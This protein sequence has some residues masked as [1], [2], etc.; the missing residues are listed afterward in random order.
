MYKSYNECDMQT[1]HFKTNAKSSGC[2]YKIDKILK[3]NPSS[4]S[5]NF[6]LV[7][8]HKILSISTD[9][10]AEDIIEM[11]NKAGCKAELVK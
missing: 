3:E 7:H 1:F 10:S 6:D 5:W 2:V 9:L 11:I 8:P 4:G